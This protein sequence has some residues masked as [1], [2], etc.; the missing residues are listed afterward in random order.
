MPAVTNR[1]VALVMAGGVGRR[2][3][4]AST[5]TRPKQLVSGLPREGATL[6]GATVARL[7][8]LAAV[9]DIHVVTTGAQAEAVRR[10]V[11]SLPPTNVLTEPC[12]RNTTACI[13]LAVA[14]V[15]SR[16]ASA[17]DEPV[18]VVAPADH[19]VQDDEA[20]LSALNRAVEVARQRDAITLLGIE[21]TEPNVGFGYIATGAPLVEGAREA[22]SR[23]LAFT[24]KPD[25]A[26]AQAYLASSDPH[27]LWNA[28]VFVMP[29]GRVERELRALRPATWRVAELA[30]SS[31][32]SET[33]D[34]LVARDY[35][36]LPDEPFDRAIVEQQADACVVPVA[37]G[38]SDLGSWTAV[39]GL[40]DPDG[41]GN[42]RVALGQAQVEVADSRGCFVWAEGV[43]VGVLGMDDVVVVARGDRLLVCRRDLAQHVGDLAKRLDPE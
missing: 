8:R 12:G 32:A 15:R 41:D 27:Y 31:G 6:L 19:H 22:G 5:P 43:R 2:L 36:A 13:A 28:G 39:E 25:K 24:E 35:A 26:T 7:Q 10:L 38:W 17:G 29:L 14:S 23:V 3:W 1:C 9:D 16:L 37:A 11:P 33:D 42:R 40:F 34:V 21:P 20:F 18:L 4:P 30:A